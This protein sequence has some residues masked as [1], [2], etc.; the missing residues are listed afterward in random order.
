MSGSMKLGL[1]ILGA[2]VAFYVLTWV[3]RSLIIVAIIAGIVLVVGGLIS[4]NGK[5]LG[6]G[7]RFLP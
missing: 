4:S 6:G 7:R 5:P 1:T 2:V 3:I